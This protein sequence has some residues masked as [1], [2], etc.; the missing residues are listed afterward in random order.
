MRG[1]IAI[2]KQQF[3]SEGWFAFWYPREY[4]AIKAQENLN[5]NKLEYNQNQNQLEAKTSI[6]LTKEDNKKIIIA[7][8][9]ITVGLIMYKYKS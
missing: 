5:N 8:I 2:G 6:I 3:D 4:S 1:K 7:I 9:I